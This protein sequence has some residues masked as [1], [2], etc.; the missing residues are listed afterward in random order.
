MLTELKQKQYITPSSLSS[1]SFVAQ[2]TA[3]VEQNQS[4]VET[5]PTKIRG[6]VVQQFVALVQ[7]HQLRPSNSQVALQIGNLA[8][9]EP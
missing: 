6:D 8:G 9:N 5:E 7:R 1:N 4:P 2:P 3:G